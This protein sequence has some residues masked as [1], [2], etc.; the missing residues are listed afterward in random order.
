MSSDERLV[1][2]VA[3]VPRLD[4]GVLSAVRS[5]SMDGTQIAFAEVYRGDRWPA[6]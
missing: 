3:V 6:R 5:F 4:R 1:V 2:V